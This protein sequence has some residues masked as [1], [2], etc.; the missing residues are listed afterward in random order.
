MQERKKSSRLYPVPLI[1]W[2]LDF[3]LQSSSSS[4]SLSSLEKSRRRR[5]RLCPSLAV[6]V[7]PSSSSLQAPSPSSLFLPGRAHLHGGR[8]PSAMALAAAAPLLP[9]FS[10]PS[11]RSGRARL[12]PSS[13]TARASRPLSSW[14]WRLS[15]APQ[16]Q[17]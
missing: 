2:L 12:A 16:P 11:P 4:A 7:S 15:M 9:L 13:T 17:R 3:F 1:R 5:R 6:P 10:E 14:P 8:A